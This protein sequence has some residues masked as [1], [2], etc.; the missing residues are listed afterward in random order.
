MRLYKTTGW[1]YCRAFSLARGG[2]PH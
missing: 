1:H 2:K